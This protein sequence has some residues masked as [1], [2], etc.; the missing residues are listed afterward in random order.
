MYVLYGYVASVSLKLGVR[1][2]NFETKIQETKNTGDF[3]KGMLIDLFYVWICN[4][5]IV[6]T[7]LQNC[8]I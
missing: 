4:F 5:G 1:P 7:D 6:R 2:I 3:L 8:F